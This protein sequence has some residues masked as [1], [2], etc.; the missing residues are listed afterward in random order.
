MTIINN[1]QK[2]NIITNIEQTILNRSSVVMY[3]V[4]FYKANGGNLND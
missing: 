2:N 1:V 3:A 4:E